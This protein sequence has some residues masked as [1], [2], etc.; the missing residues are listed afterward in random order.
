[1]ATKEKEQG[2]EGFVT[3]SKAITL[4][5]ISVCVWGFTLL[6]YKMVHVFSNINYEIFC[7]FC[8][9]ALSL[10]LGIMIS[11]NAYSK[12]DNLRFV[13]I[14][15]NIFLIYTSSNGI[16]AGNAA[17]SK[18]DEEAKE[19]ELKK[20]PEKFALFG[21]LDVRPWLP[22]ATSKKKIEELASENKYLSDRLENLQATLK[23]NDQSGII[24]SLTSQN[25]NLARENAD[26]KNENTSLREKGESSKNEDQLRLMID[27]L[28][29]RLNAYEQRV[30]GYI[31]IR[32]EWINKANSDKEFSSFA[33]IIKRRLPVFKFSEN[34][35]DQL[36]FYDLS[37][38]K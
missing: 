3:S 6:F 1:M 2:F 8:S 20:T 26:L 24:N 17:L 12:T 11:K 29:K 36:F 5:I 10:V 22:D 28:Q 16:Q 35:Y 30:N 38:P 23:T 19:A 25:E 9:F 33:T 21:L 27:S 37:A 7:L 32:G 13:A 14:L 18:P 34:Y 15:L 4:S 31:A